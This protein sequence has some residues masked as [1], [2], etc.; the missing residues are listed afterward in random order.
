LAN[1]LISIAFTGLRMMYILV[2]EGKQGLKNAITKK[3]SKADESSMANSQ[4]IKSTFQLRE[5]FY[6]IA[7]FS[8]IIM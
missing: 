4:D 7:F 8:Y 6:S 2:K 5:D 1:L 3:K